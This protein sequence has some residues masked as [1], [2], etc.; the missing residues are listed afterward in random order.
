MPSTYL[1]PAQIQSRLLTLVALFLFIQCLALTLAPA[2]RDGTW[3]V[4]YH[5]SHWLGF[6]MWLAAFAAAHHQFTRHTPDANPYLLS[7]AALLTGWGV[8]SIW[9]ILA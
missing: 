2:A 9:P 4:E 7:A 3:A 5:W 6:A 8:L 1:P